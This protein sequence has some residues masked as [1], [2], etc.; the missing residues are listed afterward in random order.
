MPCRELTAS[1]GSAIAATAKDER[2]SVLVNSGGSEQH[3]RREALTAVAAAPGVNTAR[4]GTINS[5]T[6]A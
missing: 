4:G 5:G 3:A 2:L 1:V 6:C